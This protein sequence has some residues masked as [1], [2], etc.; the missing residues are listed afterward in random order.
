MQSGP[1]T[2]RE[3]STLLGAAATWPRSAWAQQARM[4]VVG[5]LGAGAPDTFFAGDVAAFRKGLNDA[6]FV[7]GKSVAI[8]YRWAEGK[9]DRL[10][11]LAA[12]L[13]R[14][15]VAA[16]MSSGGLAPAAAAK[17]ATSTIPI[18]FVAAND[19][20]AAGLVTSLSRP[21]GNVTGVNFL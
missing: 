14:R 9:Y 20:V 17:A 18:V 8:E 7:E 16:L 6:G 2:R 3:L 12:E 5:W 13:A 1:L 15:P 11:A 4:P 10:P 19:P 21:G